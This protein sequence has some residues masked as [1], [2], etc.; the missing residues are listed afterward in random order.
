MAQAVGG[1]FGIS[2]APA[3]LGSL[4]LRME[5]AGFEPVA[6]SLSRFGEAIEDFRPFW[7]R[8]FAPAFYRLVQRNFET[9]GSLVG[10]W[11]PLSPQYAAW[12]Q[13]H[14][15]G[16]TILRRTDAL[17]HSMSYRGAGHVGP[18]GIFIAESRALVLG[19]GVP[20]AIYHQLPGVFRSRGLLRSMRTRIARRF[21]FLPQRADS[22]FGRLLHAFA[23]DA[24][25]QSGLTIVNAPTAV[26]G[27]S[28]GG[29]V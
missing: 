19:T 13:R 3:G 15:P 11:A 4:M 9:E 23:V 2:S 16:K 10:G 20:Y 26:I 28:G 14:Y 12:K 25:K 5:V 24:A 29:L 21:L 27:G 1:G 18:Q 22:T 7:T 17:F 8:Y 6:V